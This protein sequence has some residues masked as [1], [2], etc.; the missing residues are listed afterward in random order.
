MRSEEK[1]PEEEPAIPAYRQQAISRAFVQLEKAS[2]NTPINKAAIQ[3][4]PK[5]WWVADILS[6]LAGYLTQD[7]IAEVVELEDPR[8]LARIYSYLGKVNLLTKANRGLIRANG[9]LGF[10]EAIFMNLLFRGLLVKKNFDSIIN[11]KPSKKACPSYSYIMDSIEKSVDILTQ[12][13]F[14]QIMNG[15][16]FE[17]SMQHVGRSSYDESAWSDSD[18]S[19]WSDSDEEQ[20]KSI[21]NRKAEK[22]KII[23]DT[24]LGYLQSIEIF[25][26][27]SKQLLINHKAPKIIKETLIGL[28]RHLTE[29]ILDEILKYKNPQS[30]DIIVRILLALKNE[31]L[32]TQP[33]IKAV[34]SHEPPR[35]LEISISKL[36][37]SWSISLTQ[38][39]FDKLCS[40]TYSSGLIFSRCCHQ[41]VLLEL[42]RSDLLSQK[43]FEAISKLDEPVCLASTLHNLKHDNILNQEIFEEV[44]GS[45]DPLSLGYLY[46]L[47][48]VNKLFSKSNREV[49]KQSSNLKMLYEAARD[50]WFDLNPNSTSL[51]IHLTQSA[52]EGILANINSQASMAKHS[53]T[54]SSAVVGGPVPEGK[55]SLVDDMCHHGVFSISVKQRADIENVFKKEYQPERGG[56]QVGSSGSDWSAGDEEGHT[57]ASFRAGNF[58]P[59]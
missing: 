15:V 9:K 44:M 36:R 18:E 37:F 54:N 27:R 1:S 49:L 50:A 2:L 24:V 25:S 34:F 51:E 47:L 11:F 29:D 32:L 53:L 41:D 4:H 21:C 20:K 31:R 7:L 26:E 40:K 45:Q 17:H 19:A 8:D 38:E 3:K 43:N 52:I 46:S 5:P 55:D 59:T 10:L 39:N 22:R 33:N 57:P 30:L 12:E 14:D 23:I 56:E 6:D 13:I 58:G 28:G 35:A 48:Q 16:F 42:K